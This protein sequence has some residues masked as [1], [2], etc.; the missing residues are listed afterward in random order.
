MNLLRLVTANHILSLLNWSF[1]SIIEAL[2]A[3]QTYHVRAYAINED[4][5]IAYG[6]NESFTTA[7]K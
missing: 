4:A 3:G 6:Q 1:S 2:V 7:N 5:G